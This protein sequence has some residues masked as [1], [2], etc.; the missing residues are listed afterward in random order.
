MLKELFNYWKKVKRARRISRARKSIPPYLLK[1]FETELNYKLWST[2]GAR[3]SAS[4]RTG[5]LQRLS[6]QCVGYLSAYLIIVGL[7]NVYELNFWKITLSNDEVNFASVSLSVLIL[8]F[9]Q[10]ETAENFVLKSHRYHDCS[11]DIAELYNALRYTKTYESENADKGK[12]LQEISEK[13]DKILKRYENHKPIDYERFQL[14][15][16]GYFKLNLRKRLW[17]DL[18]YYCIV[19]F[20]YHLLMY[21]PLIIFMSVNLKRLILG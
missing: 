18:K 3:F 14:I 1:E 7:V 6:S 20:K 11:L 17:I 8:L 9:S 16:P 10:L 12:I 21:G 5:T 4:H 2:K 15:K 19:Y 13:Y